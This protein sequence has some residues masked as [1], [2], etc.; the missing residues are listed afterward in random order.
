MNL[1]YVLYPLISCLICQTYQ[2][3]QYRLNNLKNEYQYSKNRDNLIQ[4]EEKLSSVNEII[5]NEVIT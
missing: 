4:E 3:N 1:L 2:A 5:L